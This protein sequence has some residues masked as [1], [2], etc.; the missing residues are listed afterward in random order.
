M[1]KL[2]VKFI[3]LLYRHCSTCF[4]HY[5]AHYQEPVKLPL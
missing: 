2:I 3:A 4:E 1:Q 5:N